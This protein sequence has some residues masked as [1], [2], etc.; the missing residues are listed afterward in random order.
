RIYLRLFNRL[1]IL[2]NFI[3]QKISYGGFCALLKKVGIQINTVNVLTKEEKLEIDKF[4]KKYYGKKISYKWHNLFKKYSGKFDV[5]YIPNDVFIKYI[6]SLDLK[7]NKYNILRDKNFLY[8]LA[9]FSDIK[10]P[11]RYFYSINN[12]F[13]DANNE[14]ISKE[15]FY[16]EIFNIGE[17]FIKPTQIEFSGNSRNCRLLNIVNGIDIFSKT[18]IKDIISKYY[19]YD[20][21]VQERICCH[22]SISDIYSKS[23]NTI[24]LNTIILNNEI[25]VLKPMLKVGMG[26]CFFDYD[27]TSKK[28]LLIPIKKDGTLYDRAFCL[29]ENK[30][31]FSHPDTGITFKN[32][33]IDL[34]PEILKAAKTLQASIP[35]IPFCNMDFVIDKYGNIVVVE[36]EVP[37]CFSQI[38]YGEGFF[39]EDTKEILSFLK[40]KRKKSK[41]L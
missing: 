18:N 9:E 41:L 26:E 40:N 34:F 29:S 32:Y 11:K 24:D 25:K 6:Y 23:C 1:K 38:F 36:I 10:V 16:N 14:I 13:F 19:N 33:K 7:S 2:H 8:N 31:Y 35:W 22:K 5:R 21:I 28:G 12:I 3:K 27:R 30:E 20:F 17:I 4:Y 39:G 15:T 37:S